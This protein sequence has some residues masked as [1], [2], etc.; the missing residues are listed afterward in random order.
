MN[1]KTKRR[2]WVVAGA[3]A[4]V[5]IAVLAIVGGNTAARSVS[6]A[7][8]IELPQ[9]TKVQVSGNVVE[10]SFDIQGDS[11]TFSIYDPEADPSAT[12]T[13]QVRYDGGV[14][15][16]FGNNVTAICTGK[17]D[18]S[19]TLNCTELVTKCPSKYENAEGALALQELLAYGNSVIGKPVKVVGAI[20]EGSLSSIQ[21]DSRFTL[22]DLES[23]YDLRVLY[24]GALP[25]SANEGSQIILTGSLCEDGK[26]FE[27]TDVAL[28]G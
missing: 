27:A 20:K 28:N 17:K 23:T 15:S 9:D 19:G 18:S 5:L 26:S 25:D 1:T 6:I 2:M 10:N 3:I 4:I 14:S 21:A 24:D 11:I 13:M 12:T 22:R 8:A 16:T 7:E